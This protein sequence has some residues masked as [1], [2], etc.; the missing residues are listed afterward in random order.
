VRAINNPIPISANRIFFRIP[1][2]ASR[3][4]IISL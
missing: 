2:R 4:H 1:N 3:A